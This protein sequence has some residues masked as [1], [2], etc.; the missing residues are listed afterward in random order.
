MKAAL[1]A[2]LFAL[3]LARHGVVHLAHQQ[4]HQHQHEAIPV[5]KRQLIPPK[6]H[7]QV[8]T[9]SETHSKSILAYI[10]PS[11]GASPVPVTKQSQI[12]GSYVPEFTLCVLPPVAFYPI[13]HQPSS[14]RPSGTAPYQNY[15]ISIPSGTGSCSTIFSPTITMVCTTTLTALAKRYTVTNCAQEL[16]FST[17]Y[18]FVLVT[19][20]STSASAAASNLV[21]ILPIGTGN[22]LAVGNGIVKR[23]TGS[24]SS[25]VTTPGPSIEKLT[26]YFLAPWQQLTAGTVPQ[27]VDLKVCRTFAFNDSTECIREYQ[28]W[29]TSLVTSTATSVTTVNIST[30]IHGRS[31]LIVEKFTAN[32]TEI[33]TTFSMS[34]TMDMEY[35]TEWTSTYKSALAKS[36]STGPTV[37]ETKTLIH[38]S[39]KAS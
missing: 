19:P 2:S 25:A 17:E 21:S 28:V 29:S 10:T 32:I 34:T 27:D 7:A 15:S 1:F 38:P 13:T 5:G 20:K 14:T 37:Y 4:A 16:T 23:A 35:Q 12:V 33:L 3:A 31:Q 8:D 18:D 24:D 30:T 22:P 26:T 6:P 9:I 39:S 36:T 11:P